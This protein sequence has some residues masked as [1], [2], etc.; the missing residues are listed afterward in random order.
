MSRDWWVA[1]RP[2]G[3]R[4]VWG[5]RDESGAAGVVSSVVT[6]VVLL[7]LVAAVTPQWLAPAVDG[8]VAA[9]RLVAGLLV[10]AVAAVGEAVA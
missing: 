9:A 3:G 5:M 8:L 1:A 2:P 7:A 4:R 10:A 6:V